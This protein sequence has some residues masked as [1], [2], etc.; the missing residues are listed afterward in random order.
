MNLYIG[1]YV[2]VQ[3]WANFRGHHL[4]NILDRCFQGKEGLLNPS[5]LPNWYTFFLK[6]WC[7]IDWFHSFWSSILFHLLG[8]WDPENVSQYCAL[9]DTHDWTRTSHT[10][11]VRIWELRPIPHGPLQKKEQLYQSAGK[12]AEIVWSSHPVYVHLGTWLNQ[13]GTPWGAR[14]A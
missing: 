5:H 2:D 6:P 3:Y 9:G 4:T 13:W 1:I 7:E 8:F 12:L 11:Y 10:L 14:L